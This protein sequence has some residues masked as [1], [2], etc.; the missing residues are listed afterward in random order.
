MARVDG[1]PFTF[2]QEVSGTGSPTSPIYQIE[3]ASAG[4]SPYE[5]M[6][7]AGLVQEPRTFDCNESQFS[8]VVLGTGS[9]AFLSNPEFGGA[10]SI[11]ITHVPET[12][13]DLLEGKFTATVIDPNDGAKRTLTEGAFR[14]P[15]AF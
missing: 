14:V 6:I 1:K 11:E 2:D 12:S 5:I 13:G 8:G 9:D 3:G 7:T 10:C 15:V 4:S